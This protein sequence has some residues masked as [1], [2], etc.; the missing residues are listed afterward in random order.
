MIIS[1]IFYEYYI[2]RNSYLMNFR[3]EIVFY[4]EMYIQNTDSL[5]VK[6]AYLKRIENN[7]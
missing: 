1:L 3:I 6:I 5:K 7:E 4:S 2:A